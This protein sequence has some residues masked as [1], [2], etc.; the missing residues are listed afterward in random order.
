VWVG[1]GGAYG[2]PL[3]LPVEDGRPVAIVG[4]H[5]SGRSTT[6][7]HLRRRLDAAGRNAVALSGHNGAE[8]PDVVDALEAGAVVLLDDLEAAG[9]PPPGRLP[10]AGTLVAAYTT[11]TA[12]TFRPPTQLF[13]T[14]PLGVLLWSGQPGSGAA[15]GA[16]RNGAPP[17]ELTGPRAAEPPGRGRLVLGGRSYSVQLAA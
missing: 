6:L 8:W 17:V 1:L 16:G 9:G 3:A 11:A 7:A 14:H 5:G 12:T 13:H 15:F 10:T 2:A 4:P